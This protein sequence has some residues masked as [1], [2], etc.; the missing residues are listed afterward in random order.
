M[1][2]T[3]LRMHQDI[4]IVKWPTKENDFFIGFLQSLAQVLAIKYSFILHCSIFHGYA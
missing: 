2:Y 3:H 1:A 4:P